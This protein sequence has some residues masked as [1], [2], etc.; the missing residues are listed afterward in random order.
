MIAA[1]FIQQS[2]I[3]NQKTSRFPPRIV[4]G[5][6]LNLHASRASN[7]PC[8]RSAN[9]IFLNKTGP[10]AV[11]RIEGRGVLA[12]EAI[13]SEAAMMER[14]REELIAEL[15][16]CHSRMVYR[17]AYAA[18]RSHHEAED[19]T[20]ETFLRVLRHREKLDSLDDPKSWLARIA[21]RVA[22]DRSKRIRRE[23][24]GSLKEE[25]ATQIASYEDPADNVIQ[26]A[27]LGAAVEKLI[28]SLPTKLREPLVLSTV[29]E[30]SPQEVA[31]ALSINEAAVR[32]RVF[33]ARKILKERLEQM[34]AQRQAKSAGEDDA[35]R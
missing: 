25:P 17:I 16:H 9:G 5:L 4:G 27:Q 24:E 15:V 32:S 20:Q 23:Q 21:W 28:K 18:L 29:E 26:G 13:L 3:S 6:V 12:G 11:F 10:R 7:P 31:A 33:R 22:V 19:A 8:K 34:Q 1:I 35:P 30:M 14:S 2:E